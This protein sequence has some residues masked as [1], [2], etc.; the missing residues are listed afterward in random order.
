MLRRAGRVGIC[1]DWKVSEFL[2]RRERA[3]LKIVQIA[4]LYVVFIFS[5]IVTG[6]RI[7]LVESYLM[8]CSYPPLL[9]NTIGGKS[10][11]VLDS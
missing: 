8:C 3:Q 9:L 11:A 1:R 4:L 2:K 5:A 10:N 7:L 6:T